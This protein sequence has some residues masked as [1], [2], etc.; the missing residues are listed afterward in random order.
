MPG[1]AAPSEIEIEISFAQYVHDIRGG[2]A[3]V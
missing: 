1:V 3:E 2:L